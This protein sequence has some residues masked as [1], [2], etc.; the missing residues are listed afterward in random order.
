MSASLKTD[1]Q[2]Q[3]WKGENKYLETL[4]AIRGKSV[5]SVFRLTLFTNES[6]EIP[7]GTSEASCKA[8]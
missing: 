2:R 8:S 7:F 4:T 1:I 5:M 6:T 3:V